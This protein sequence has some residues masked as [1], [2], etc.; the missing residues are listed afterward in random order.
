MTEA[1]GLKDEFS[2][3]MMKRSLQKEFGSEA[4]SQSYKQM[5]YIYP[6]KRVKIGDSWKN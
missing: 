1:S 3:K 6:E 4:L 2:L 5:T